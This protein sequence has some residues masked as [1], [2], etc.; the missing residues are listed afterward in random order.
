M[1]DLGKSSRGGTSTD[2]SFPGG[3]LVIVLT[4]ATGSGKTELL[5]ALAARG[6]QSLD[7]ER[8][9]GH[10]GSAFGGLDRKAQPSHAAFQGEVRAALARAR[11]DRPL[12]VEDKGDYVGSVGLP[13]ELIIAL[14]RSPAVEVREDSAAARVRRILDGYGGADDSQWLR[15][16]DL[17]APRLGPE[18]TARVRAALA[19]GDRG[20]A[21]AVLLNYYDAGYRHRAATL[22]RPVLGTVGPT[23]VDRAI[24]L[25]STVD[26][27][28][29]D[30]QL[31]DSAGGEVGEGQRHVGQRVGALD[32]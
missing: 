15:S 29:P 14:G 24:R 18:R 4:G 12:W 23:D 17:I 8:L 19:A 30:R 11:A 10:R 6:E 28:D 31:A 13:P 27:A 22:R 26:S 2:R 5:A 25:A 7:L 1:T 20:T 3:H 16:V 32:R 21:V 9:A